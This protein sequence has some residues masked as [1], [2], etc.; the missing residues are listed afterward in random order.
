GME[1]EQGWVYLLNQRLSKNSIQYKVINLSISGETTGGGLLRL[2]QA[3]Q[4]HQPKIIIIELGGNDG[5]RGYPIDRIRRNLHQMVSISKDTG[6]D[7]L[8]VGMMLPP[9]YGRRYSESFQQTFTDVAEDLKVS[10]LP[11]L[12]EG[13]ATHED[14]MQRDGIHPN[15]SAQKMLLDN[16]WPVITELLDEAS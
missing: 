15:P 7:V 8:L 6:A 16:I 4:R 5:L 14:L 12:L 11:F 2:P 3:I 10:L 13:V 1:Q 9:N